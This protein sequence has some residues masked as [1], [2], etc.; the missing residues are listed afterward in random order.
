MPNL[1]LPTRL[2][3]HKNLLLHY[4]DGN[5]YYIEWTF[6]MRQ[7]KE[8]MNI[9]I[10]MRESNDYASPSAINLVNK[11]MIHQLKITV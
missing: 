6:W 10:E 9:L 11:G 3:E 5:G 7:L 2:S 4:P 1:S 8:K